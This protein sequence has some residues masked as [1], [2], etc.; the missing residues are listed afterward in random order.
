MISDEQTRS[1]LAAYGIEASPLQCRQVRAYIALLLKWNRSIAL[2]A[3]T[4]E[5]EILRFHF[6]ESVFALS[7][8]MGISGRLADVGAGAGFPGLPLRIFN[9]R[10]ELFLIESNAKKCAFLNQVVSQ[11]CLGGVQVIRDR[12]E[13]MPGSMRGHVDVL[14][15]R[16][17][18][19]YTELVRW[20]AAVLPPAG[21]IVLWLGENEAAK[22][23]EKEPADSWLWESKILIPGS[24]RRFLLVGTRV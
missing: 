15:T 10:I 3:V 4:D 1:C 23:G 18:G 9:D 16:A 14:V 19:S 7:A 17:L 24:S 12:Y 22:I 20:A 2:T 13:N 5:V 8:V 6:G 11:L 21:R